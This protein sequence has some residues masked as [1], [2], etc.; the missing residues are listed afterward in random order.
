MQSQP[1]EYLT[2]L[3]Q[4]G[5]SSRQI[6][7]ATG[8]SKSHVHKLLLKAGYVRSK[9]AANI[10]RQ[11]STSNHWR[12]ARTA[13]RRIME[14]HLGRKLRTDEHVHHIDEDYTN[15]SLSNLEVLDAERH[16]DLHY[17]YRAIPYEQR[18][19]RR[20]YKRRYN[21][22]APKRLRRLSSAR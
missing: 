8:M 10:I 19:T 14:R 9:S 17:P 16:Y 12:S 2:F 15:R 3:W 11:P 21:A 1:I 18:E 20:A 6:A 4:Q 7:K 13:A 5:L 22:N